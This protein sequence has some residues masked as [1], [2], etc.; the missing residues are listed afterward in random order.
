MAER[1][2]I[3]SVLERRTGNG[4][5]D[6]ANDME[7]LAD[8][9][10]G[11]SHSVRDFN[12]EMETS[13]RRVHDLSTEWAR[14]PTPKITQDLKDARKEL[15]EFERVAKAITPAA[16]GGILGS[17]GELGENLRGA[18]VPALAAAA[19]AAAPAISAAIGAAVLGS[20]GIGGVVGGFIAAAHDP[21][22]PAAFKPLG[23]EIAESIF[24]DG[25]V[26]VGPALMAAD[27]IGEAWR[28][29]IGPHV[30]AIFSDLAPHAPALTSG[31]LG[32][33]DKLGVGLENAARAAGPFLDQLGEDL[34][35]LGE[36]MG[37][38]FSSVA[39]AGPEIS[40]FFHDL[41]GGLG[42]TIEL[43]G[44]GVQFGA[45]FNDLFP[46]TLVAM[47][48]FAEATGLNAE[49]DDV[50]I[51]SL[52]GVSGAL[53]NLKDLQERNNAVSFLFQSNMVAAVST[54]A[55]L[56]REVSGTN[57]TLAS[58]AAAAAAA[59]AQNEDL[60]ASMQNAAQA[61]NGLITAFDMLNGAEL[62]QREALRN[63][64]QAV[65]TFQDALK[66]S[67]GSLDI[68][69]QAGRTA[70]EAMD[71]LGQSAVVAAQSILDNGGTVEEAKKAYD[72]YIGVLRN[73]LAQAGLTKK[74]IDELIGSITKMPTNKT[75]NVK[76]SGAQAA[77]AA[78][79]SVRSALNLL[80]DKTVTLHL[81][82]TGSL[83][84]Q[85]NLGK[86]AGFAEGGFV[87]GSKGAPMLA[88]VHGGE[89]VSTT[90]DVAAARRFGSRSSSGS[91]GPAPGYARVELI[92]SAEH[93]GELTRQ[94]VHVRGGDVQVLSTRRY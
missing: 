33:V 85:G 42:S 22:V 51:R 74:Q 5:R 26:F 64:E 4:L 23:H 81:A 32:F 34:P 31:L 72:H 10:D 93:V 65:D 28:A 84:V 3:L 67:K 89:Y 52:F 44:K 38:F 63:A 69:T 91:G 58:N 13:R 88:V 47:G 9:A 90:D 18:M 66:V 39:K 11:T 29:R 24:A 86:V 36:S 77:K 12:S 6:A 1:D 48:R 49:A 14:T 59:S 50:W 83:A 27:Q 73:T 82:T 16:A 61:A 15:R 57:L 2:L 40:A 92:L 41:N 80:H 17:L 21:R 94:F 70:Q 54:A 45:E 8:S 71:R 62:S 46:G 56:A 37:S 20:V 75:V 87:P 68:H 53:M 60:T 30:A 35:K 79:D 43:L 78:I 7:R 25:R 55:Q 76:Q 19:V